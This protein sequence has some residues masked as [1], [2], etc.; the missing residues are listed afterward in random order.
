[1]VS[2]SANITWDAVTGA[3]SYVIRYGVGTAVADRLHYSETPNFVLNDAVFAG[4]LA[5]L[6][7]H[8][9]VEAYPKIYDGA[10]EIEKANNA[11]KDTRGAWSQMLTINYP[12]V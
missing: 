3:K 8:V 6:E 12:T 2:D 10:D 11:M 5:G 1:M 9:F 4:T 7:L